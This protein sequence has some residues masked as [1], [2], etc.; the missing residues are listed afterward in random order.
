MITPTFKVKF[1]DNTFF[2]G[3]T[4]KGDWN[5]VPSK[6]IDSLL[7]SI[8]SKKLFL[9]GYSEYNHLIENIAI[10]GSNNTAISKILIMAR[11]DKVTDIFEINFKRQRVLK[12]ETAY[13]QEYQNQILR[14]WHSG[15]LNKPSFQYV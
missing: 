10:I 4:F 2:K 9:K 7:Y 6:T 1:T 14:G 5:H 8:G 15:Q 13:G 3:Q 12:Y 11:K